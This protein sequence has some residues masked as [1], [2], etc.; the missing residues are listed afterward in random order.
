MK[1]VSMADDGRQVISVLSDLYVGQKEFG[2]RA[3]TISGLGKLGFP[4]A[5]GYFISFKIMN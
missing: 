3:S 4:I 1:I 2:F 5:P